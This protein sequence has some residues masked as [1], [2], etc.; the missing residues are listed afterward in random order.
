MY[1]VGGA[2]VI[3]ST[4]RRAKEWG[5]VRE[6]ILEEPGKLFVHTPRSES[7]PLQAGELRVSTLYGGICGSDLKVYEGHLAHAVYPVRPGHEVLAVVTEAAMGLRLYQGIALLSFPIR[8]VMSVTDVS[9]AR[10]TSVETSNRLA[11]TYLVAL[12]TNGWLQPSTRYLY[13]KQYPIEWRFLSSHLRWL[14]T[15]CAKYTFAK[16]KRF[17]SAVAGRKGHYARW[18]PELGALRLL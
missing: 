6:L 11:S 3:F 9:G 8:F 2:Y 15:Q 1:P 14:C 4:K 10:Q 12:L 18:L 5:Q 7:R 17:S 13:R 16:V